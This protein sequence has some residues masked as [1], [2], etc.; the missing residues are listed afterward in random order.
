MI[1]NKLRLVKSR[2]VHLLFKGGKIKKD[3]LV[4]KYLPSADNSNHF[5]VIVSA[6][7]AKTAVARNRLRRQIYEIIRIANPTLEKKYN[8]AIIAQK[9]TPDTD[10][11]QL[12]ENILNIFNI[13][14]RPK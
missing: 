11:K 8:I 1:P 12:R 13:I 3:C 9:N 5:C 2:I 10:F 6:K 4:V 14:N 7:I